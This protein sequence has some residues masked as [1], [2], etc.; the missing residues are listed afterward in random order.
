MA[1][2]R[3]AVEF[4]G[5]VE[6]PTCWHVLATP[7]A[8]LRELDGDDLAKLDLTPERVREDSAA[9]VRAH[10]AVLKKRAAAERAAH[11]KAQHRLEKERYEEAVRSAERY[12]E[13]V[14]IVQYYTAF[15]S[16][17]KTSGVA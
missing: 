12:E 2:A 5:E 14:Q 7:S 10:F 13:S 6:V 16:G 15:A 1:I 4:L 8:V 11:E 3:K 17:G 9:H